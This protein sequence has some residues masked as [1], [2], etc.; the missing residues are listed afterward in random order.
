MEND[1]VTQVFNLIGIPEPTGV[2][3]SLKIISA[4]IS[5]VLGWAV[6]LLIFK[7]GY[8][9]YVKGS[10]K[11]LKHEYEPLKSSG[12]KVTAE[13][14]RVLQRM[15]SGDEA[16]F[17]MAIIEADKLIDNLIKD[18]GYPGDSMGE[19]LKLIDESKLKNIDKLW[20]AHKV[21]N[22]IVHDPDFKLNYNQAQ[23]AIEIYQK[24]LEEFEAL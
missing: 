20:N 12:D 7:S 21:R 17:K 16:N 9:S 11:L 22:N 18:M 8:V 2:I 1:L 3:L 10:M 15:E 14:R 6:L 4:F 13:W 5:I 19:R 24:V 23:N